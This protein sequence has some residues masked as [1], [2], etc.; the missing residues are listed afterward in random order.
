MIPIALTIAGSDSSGG[1]GLQADL[2]A[3]NGTGVIMR[4]YPRPIFFPR[5][6]CDPF[7]LTTFLSTRQRVTSST[8]LL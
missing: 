3:D 8:R 5:A 2:G 7:I 4:Y 1:A 6:T